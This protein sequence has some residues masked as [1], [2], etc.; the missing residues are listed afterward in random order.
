[1]CHTA[2]ESKRRPVRPGES[3]G[4]CGAGHIRVALTV[5]ETEIAE[6][7]RRIAL[8]ARQLT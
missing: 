3:F 2:G 1:M 6:A 8:L 5:S 4:A 7:A